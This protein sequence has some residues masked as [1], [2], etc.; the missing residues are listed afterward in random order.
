MAGEGE[1]RGADANLLQEDQAQ[2][3]LRRQSFWAGIYEYFRLGAP[4]ALMVCLEWWAYQ[5]MMFVCGY[6]GVAEQAAQ[7]L[8]I[9][10]SGL[11]FMAALG[12]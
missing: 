1:G 9:N 4:C 11:L 8:I 3:A 10:M 2:E 6:I 5:Y 12:C 7:I